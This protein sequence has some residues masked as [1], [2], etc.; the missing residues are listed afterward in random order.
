MKSLFALLLLSYISL[1]LTACSD[2]AKDA[3]PAENAVD[4]RILNW[5]PKETTVHTGFSVQSNGNSALWFEQR[6][7]PHAGAAELWL[8]KTVL[9]GA[10][11]TPNVGGSAEVPPALIAKPG[12]Y[13]VYLI[14]KPQNQ[15]VDLGTFEVLP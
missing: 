8:D 9:P 10:V 15:R 7:I 6:G 14:L 4:V 5:G 3:L 11:I 1:S 12:K 2:G 13:P